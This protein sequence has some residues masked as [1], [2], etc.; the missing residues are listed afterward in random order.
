MERVAQRI[1]L[2]RSNQEEYLRLHRS[3]WPEVEATLT[4]AGIRNYSIF[5][6]DEMLFAYF[7]IDSATS[8]AHASATIAQ[9]PKTREWW[10]LTDPL[11]RR[12]EG[13][14]DNEQW[15][16]LQEIWHLD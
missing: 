1:D 13:T 8:F 10:K 12:V 6:A 14:P 5:L 9:D 11:Q 15:F 7:E 3:V 4:R 16:R 2:P